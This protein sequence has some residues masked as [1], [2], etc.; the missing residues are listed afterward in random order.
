[1]SGLFPSGPPSVLDAPGEQV[2]ITP[3]VESTHTISR[4]MAARHAHRVSVRRIHDRGSSGSEAGTHFTPGDVVTSNFGLP[5]DANMPRSK[6]DRLDPK[7]VGMSVGCKNLY[8][9]EE[10]DK[11]RFQWQPTI[12]EDIGKPA[13][14][15]E[16]QKWAL[17]A[18]Y[19]K[20]WGDPQ[21][22][23]TLHSI[24]IQS[25]FLQQVLEE[26]LHNYPGVTPG[27]KRLEFTDRFEPLIHRFPDLKKKLEDLK[28]E[29]HV[30]IDSEAVVQP[31]QK[32]NVAVSTD[33]NPPTRDATGKDVSG[34]DTEGTDSSISEA[35][36]KIRH[37]QLLYDLLVTECQNVV[38]S[39]QDM[40]A[41]SVMTYEYLW[42]LFQPG[43]IIWSR[44]DGQ[45]C[46]HRLQSSKYDIDNDCN[47]VFR[48]MLLY[49]DYDGSKFGYKMRS[50]SICAY[51]GTK[52]ITS[53][54]AFPLDFH[55]R[56]AELVQNLVERGSKVEYFAGTHYRAYDGIGWKYDQ[57]GQKEKFTVKGRI[58][59]DA[60]GWNRYNP[61]SAIYVA[62]FNS[63]DVLPNG[64]FSLPMPILAVPG[65]CFGC[66][67]ALPNEDSGLGMPVDGHFADEDE[68]PKHEPLTTDQKLMCTAVLRGYA[69]KEKVWLNFFVNSVHD[70]AFNSR[71]FETLVLPQKQKELVL[72]FTATQQAYRNAYDDVIEGKGR[73]II[74]LLCGPPGVGKTLTAESVAEEMK[75]P[76]FI[77]SA[78]DLGM[79]SRTIEGRLLVILSMCTRWN[80]ILL[81]DE[82]DIFLEERSLHELERNKLVSIF[83]RLVE[84]N[85][86][87]MFLT[88]NRVQTFD[89]AFQSR[90][91]ISLDYPELSIES[92]NTVWK[93]F[94]KQHNATQE[95]ARERPP[96]NPISAIKTGAATGTTEA[97]TSAEEIRKKHEA[98]TQPHA[99]TE[100]QIDQL[101]LMNMN[102]RQI[103]NVLKT[104]QLLAS[105]KGEVLQHSHIMTVLDVTQH[106]HNATR[107]SE[108]TRSSIF[109]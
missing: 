71:A 79:D 76:L 18:R 81:L 80:A 28:N 24:V 12:P 13:E 27:L 17:I 46:A 16:T 52:S 10:D 51:E 72:G 45:D 95:S 98:A 69:L 58:V 77:M 68:Q 37:T 34:A 107:E 36:L 96:K 94:L 3:F 31:I 89:P 90:I 22:V 88:T 93:N 38:E 64:S 49:V 26:V 8:S 55:P 5:A 48:L 85:E 106:L 103:K 70:I 61:N 4:R 33:N 84:Y 74:I 23:L 25:P 91:H 29:V 83:L 19:V 56:K 15:A 35:A 109:T 63:K 66:T 82:A 104:A 105:H 30:T 86:G 97:T 14:D 39:S 41:Q 2:R 92:R 20:A 21:K 7:L 78:G 9:G 60:V 47:P 50:V 87:I 65:E 100:R 42:T 59:V 75:V 73:G 40:K 1:M 62:S 67:I 53:L 44:Q 57:Y 54:V 11:G 6:V 43:Q 108:R 32:P 101:A 102:G 99:I